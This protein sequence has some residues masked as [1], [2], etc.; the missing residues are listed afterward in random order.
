MLPTAKNV[1]VG[2]GWNCVH[3]RNRADQLLLHN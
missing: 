1:P 3:T 2:D